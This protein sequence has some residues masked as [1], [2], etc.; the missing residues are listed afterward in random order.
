L[1]VEES[2]SVVLLLLGSCGGVARATYGGPGAVVELVLASVAAVGG[3]SGGI[4]AGLA[5]ADCVEGFLR[6]APGEGCES[7]ALFAMQASVPGCPDAVCRLTH[8]G[9]QALA[10]FEHWERWH[11]I[12]QTDAWLRRILAR[13]CDRH[14]RH[15][16]SESD[17]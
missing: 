8:F 11:R 16:E 7:F 10:R 17:E 12:G 6:D 15:G 1:R 13:S 14:G 3:D 2:C 4:A 5:G 9:T